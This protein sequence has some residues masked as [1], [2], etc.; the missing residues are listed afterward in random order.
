MKI[1]DKNVL[2]AMPGRRNG[3]RIERNIVNNPETEE[4]K[5][6][7]APEQTLR[8]MPGRRT[9]RRVER[10]SSEDSSLNNRPTSV[11][12][13]ENRLSEKETIVAI[14][15]VQKETK[16]TVSPEVEKSATT[17]VNEVE[18]DVLKIEEGPV[19]PEKAQ[20]KEEKTPKKKSSGLGGKAIA[21]LVVIAVIVA[22]LVFGIIF[23]TGKEK[24]SSKNYMDQLR[25]QKIV[26]CEIKPVNQFFTDYYNSLSAGNT[27]DL[28]NMFDDPEKANV[29]AGISTIVE[30]YSDLEIYLT[31]G[32][33][34]NEYVVFVC[35]NVKFNNIKS[36]Y[37]SI[38]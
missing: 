20:E 15:E 32:M 30:Q 38:L 31:E 1:E 2:Q 14:D 9:A 17:V 10:R 7:E 6:S 26:Q 8:S 24:K 22:A 16:E 3:R 25:T 28:E 35:N 13:R 11:R 4:T 18:K 34:E 19:K 33:K 23:L 5:T 21:I 37:T 27:T 12:R 36:C 29:S